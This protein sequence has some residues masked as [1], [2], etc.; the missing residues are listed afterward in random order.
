M[1]L[2]RMLAAN[3]PLNARTSDGQRLETDT[4]VGAEYTL[5]FG[6]EVILTK[7]LND[8][9]EIRHSDNLGD[10]YIFVEILNNELAFSGKI[11]QR[12]TITTCDGSIFPVTLRPEFLQVED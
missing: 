6:G 8:G 2:R 12:L 1:I 5:D 7:A 4:A 11:R 10:G 3:Y 9:L